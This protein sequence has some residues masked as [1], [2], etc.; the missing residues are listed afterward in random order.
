MKLP[1]ATRCCELAGNAMSVN[2]VA[3]LFVAISKAVGRP[4]DDAWATGG[5]L[6]A[7]VEDAARGSPELEDLDGEV[8]E[9]IRRRYRCGNSREDS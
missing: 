9:M 3:R 5:A 7:L 6:D 8:D 2:V 4:I 1:E